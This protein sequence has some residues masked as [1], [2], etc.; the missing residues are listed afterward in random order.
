MSDRIEA[1]PFQRRDRSLA[2]FVLSGRW[3]DSTREWAQF[4]ALAVRITAIPGMVISTA[5]FRAIE[6]VPEDPEPGT[7]GLV[8][9]EGPV[10]SDRGPKPGQFI[11]PQPPALFVLHPPHDNTNPTPDSHDAASGA[12]FLPGIPHLGIDHRAAWVEAEADGTIT[13]LVTATDVN[14]MTD[15]DLAVL[16]TLCAA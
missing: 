2:G 15:A 6:E 14:P 1:A 9:D 10:L 4:L 11:H 3:P 12:L 7:V 8:T 16:A 13:R 5:I